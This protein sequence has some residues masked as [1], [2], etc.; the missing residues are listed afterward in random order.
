MRVGTRAMLGARAI[1]IH[2][3][4][5]TGRVRFGNETW[6]ARSARNIEVGAEVEITGVDRLTLDVRPIAKEA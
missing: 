6:N 5:P 4:A 3:I 2:R 1:V